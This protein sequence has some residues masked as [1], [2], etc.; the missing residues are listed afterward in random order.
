MQRDFSPVEAAGVAALAVVGFLA[1]WATPLG[2]ILV[3]LFIAALVV[4][5][6]M[7]GGDMTAAAGSTI[8]S[9]WRK[10][11]A[12]IELTGAT[13]ARRWLWRAPALATLAGFLL[14]WG[15]NLMEAA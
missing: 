15:A 1:G 5:M 3:A 9:L 8:A 10:A 12:P 11:L 4:D 2:T 13:P 14:R 6:V 7:G